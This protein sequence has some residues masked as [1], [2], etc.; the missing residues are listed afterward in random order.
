MG[1]GDRKNE[2]RLGSL[3]AM[4]ALAASLVVAM[5]IGS[6]TAY[7]SPGP[8]SLVV[9]DT[10]AHVGHAGV[11]A[12]FVISGFIMFFIARRDGREGSPAA[13]SL[14]FLVRRALRIYPAFWLSLA[15]FAVLPVQPWRQ[16]DISRL[17]PLMVF[18]LNAPGALH[19][20][21]W[22]MVFEVTFYLGVGV[23][24][25]LS[26]HRLALAFAVL[27]LAETAVVAF[28]AA[29]L[30]NVGLPGHPMM[31]EFVVG[32]GAAFLVEAG[33]R[34]SPVALI[35]AGTGALALSMSLIDPTSLPS[36]PQLRI[37]GFAL[38]AAAIL[39]GLVS[40]ERSRL[41]RIPRYLI[42]GGDIS[43]SIYLWHLPVL[44]GL[45]ELMRASDAFAWRGSELLFLAA[46]LPLI[47]IFSLVSYRLLEAPSIQL[48][49][50]LSWSHH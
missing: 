23:I 8:V 50:S 4:R 14:R 22:S 26:G 40:L 46:A 9:Q 35:T 12:F 16:A 10:L 24:L 27:C 37:F 1:D 11:D 45:G 13:N 20:V 28:Q 48:S 41:I 2:H 33:I 6:V 29:G 5:H 21:A 17:D 25:L 18:L 7:Y 39:C 36:C 42:Q 3:Q 30:V 38:P 44:I 31:L 15:A 43:Y 49:R 32:I 19:P 34:T 47:L